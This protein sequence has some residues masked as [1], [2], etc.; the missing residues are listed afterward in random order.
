MSWPDGG[1]DA[2]PPGEKNTNWKAVKP[3]PLVVRW[4]RA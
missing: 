1:H 2:V 4:A 3:C